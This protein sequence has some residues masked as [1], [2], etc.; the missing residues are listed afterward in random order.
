[1]AVVE[2]RPSVGGQLSFRFAHAFFRQTLYEE[3]FAARRIRVHQQVARALEAAY[4]RRVEEHAVELAEHYAN[5][6]DPG[7]LAKSVHYSE[8]AAQRA[9]SVFAYGEAVRHLEQALK[10]QEVLD[11]DDKL[12]RCD[13]LL[14]L[15]EAMMSAGEPLRTA[16]HVAEEAFDL[17]Q[18]SDDAARTSAVCSLAL[19]ALFRYG[20]TSAAPTPI[21]RTWAARADK[22]AQDNTLGRVHADLALGVGGMMEERGFE[23]RHF[24]ER[25]LQLARR[26]GDQRAI[27]ECGARLLLGTESSLDSWERG[28]SLA[29]ELVHTQRVGVRTITLAQVLSGSGSHFL[30]WGDRD[31]LEQLW[32][33]VDELAHRTRD[34]YV[35]LRPI[36]H[37]LVL[38]TLNG[39]LE[40]AVETAERL[41]TTSE[42]MGSALYG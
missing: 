7:D 8:V 4:G 32:R 5:S 42:E 35:L 33:E 14:A 17:A 31:R 23:R 25:A 19:E 26:L 24:H 34:P 36:I 3:L 16:E 37:S 15:G 38:N 41:M 11:P 39:N 30:A 12:K 27:F 6:S 21:W 9:L 18:G 28:R 40:G 2:Q 29:E 10:A 1:R 20:G 13:I 22:S